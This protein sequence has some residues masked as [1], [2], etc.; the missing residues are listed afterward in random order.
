[1]AHGVAIHQQCDRAYHVPP[2]ETRTWF[3]TGIYFDEN[4]SP[5]TPIHLITAS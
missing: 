1:M 3:H 5:I 2:V 4:S